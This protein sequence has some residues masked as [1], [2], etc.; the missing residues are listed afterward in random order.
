M[1][2]GDCSDDSLPA[3]DAAVAAV[4]E[5]GAVGVAVRAALDLV[6]VRDPRRREREGCGGARGGGAP[7]DDTAAEAR[8]EGVGA[9][10]P[11]LVAAGP[12]RGADSGGERPAEG[13]GG[14]RDDPVEEPAPAR[15]HDRD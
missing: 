11:P 5:E 7:R 15:V 14:T 12:D 6:D 13:C 8:A 4:G 10:P 1:R 2:S 9:P 3:R